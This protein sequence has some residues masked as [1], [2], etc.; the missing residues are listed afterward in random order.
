MRRRDFIKGIV[1]SG[2]FW[3]CAARAQGGPP[4]RRIGMLMTVMESDPATQGWINSFQRRLAELGWIEDGNVR[5]NRRWAAGNP[6]RIRANVAEIIGLRPDVIVA[7]NT[8][9]VAALHKETDSIPIVFVQ[10]SDPVGDGFVETLARPGGNVTGFTNTMSTLGG[11]WLELLREAA[12]GLSRVGY[13]LNRAASPGGDAY[14]LEPFEA[15]AKSLGLTSV[16][17]EPR[18]EGEIDPAIADFAA[19]SGDGIVTN[20]DAFIAVNRDRII[21]AVNQHRL[22]SANCSAVFAYSGGF[23]SY[24]ADTVQQWQAAAG[25]VDRILR[26]D[27]P[28]ELPVQLPA[29]F[30]LVINLK[31]AK[32]L[33][34]TIP[35]TLLAR[36]DEVIE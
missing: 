22:P 16:L 28:R 6:E 18:N 24:G 9:M 20:C 25:Y 4:V 17:L 30:E 26:G 35:Q 5:F 29:K 13:L 7:Q 32:A 3:P 21:S 11:K 33:G 36:A 1:G 34:V 2:T 15:A 31:T 8:P 23:L 10:V 12:P 27:N 19:A 14:Y